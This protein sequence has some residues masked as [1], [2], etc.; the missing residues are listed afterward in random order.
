MAA[1]WPRMV[2][3]LIATCAILLSCAPDEGEDAATVHAAYSALID[4][5]TGPTGYAAISGSR[6]TVTAERSIATQPQ[7]P[8]WV[9]AMFARKGI[10]VVGR[11]APLCPGDY[12]LS[13]G[14]ARQESRH[15]YQ[16]EVDVLMIPAE[17]TFGDSE[18]YD[19]RVDCRTGAC[20]AVERSQVEQGEIGY[21]GPCGNTDTPRDGAG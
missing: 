17:Y 1:D 5:L 11:E 15:V 10:P 21:D 20:A 3:H 7:A 2:L 12:R 4:S 16:I 13:L 14:P 18:I 6:L 9:I 8:R 19:Y